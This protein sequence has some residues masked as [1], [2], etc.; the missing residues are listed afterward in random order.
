LPSASMGTIMAGGNLPHGYSYRP[1]SFVEQQ[2][3][4]GETYIDGFV[5]TPKTA[6]FEPLT[7]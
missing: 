1:R 6:V 2:P 5:K 7:H 3:D 4:T